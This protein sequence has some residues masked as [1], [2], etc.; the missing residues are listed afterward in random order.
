MPPDLWY[1]GLE[2]QLS[3]RKTFTP[4]HHVIRWIA[5]KKC[6][7]KNKPY[8]PQEN[9]KKYTWCEII[10]EKYYNWKKTTGIIHEGWY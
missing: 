3:K 9:Y 10:I 5:R 2:S 8:L 1:H 4:M 7:G 6:L